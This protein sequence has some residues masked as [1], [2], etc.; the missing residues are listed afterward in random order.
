MSPM[1]ISFFLDMMC[2]KLMFFFKG[3]LKK[4]RKN[5][6]LAH[7]LVRISMRED[8]DNIR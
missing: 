2:V 8:D 4:I 5:A 6:R 3:K 1:R 7:Q